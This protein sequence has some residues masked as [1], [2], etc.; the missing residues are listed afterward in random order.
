MKING[1]DLLKDKTG[2]YKIVELFTM[3]LESPKGESC[4]VCHK[5]HKVVIDEYIRLVKGHRY[6]VIQSIKKRKCF[7]DKYNNYYPMLDQ[8]ENK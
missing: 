6:K 8:K 3:E 4:G 7:I 1:N 2:D 5:Q